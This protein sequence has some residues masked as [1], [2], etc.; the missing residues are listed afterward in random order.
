MLCLKFGFVQSLGLIDEE[1]GKNT[2]PLYCAVCVS[3]LR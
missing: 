3:T 1:E 2:T